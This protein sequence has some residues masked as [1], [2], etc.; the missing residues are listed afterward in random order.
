MRLML[1]WIVLITLLFAK[2]ESG[3]SYKELQRVAKESAESFLKEYQYIGNT[4]K[5]LVI[6]DFYN[7]TDRDIDIEIFS[8]ALA[9][10][11]RS[12]GKF[13]LTNTITGSGAKADHMVF[14]ARELR[15][16]EEFSSGSLTKQ[17]QLIAPD[18]S[19]SG[20]IIQ[21]RD[22][23]KM[24]YIFLLTLTDI[25]TGLIVW[26][27]DFLISQKTKNETSQTNT[28]KER[29]SFFVLGV[30]PGLIFVDSEKKSDEKK[31]EFDS[32]NLR[33]SSGYA[34]H[35][36]EDTAFSL[37]GIYA[38]NFKQ[39]EVEDEDDAQEK[40][41]INAIRHEVGIGASLT[42]SYLHF[43]GGVMFDLNQQHEILEKK[44]HPFGEVGLIFSFRHI[45]ISAIMRYKREEV[46]VG[47]GFIF[48]F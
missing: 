13:N 5:T 35:M 26:D 29:R 40:E 37:L 21:R 28:S 32:Y 15:R 27:K 34:Y 44:I 2:E 7:D 45:G 36:N 17:G 9:R 22:A 23:A 1:V 18:L 6:S 39:Q 33:I 19:L 20:K 11:I 12:S 31:L 48:A 3:I 42:W 41:I 43:G 4:K 46:G 38:G 30:E 16:D 8:R 10:G 47:L 14:G 25:K 24:D